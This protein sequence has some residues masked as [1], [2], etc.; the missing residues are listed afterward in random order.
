MSILREDAIQLNVDV[1]TAEMAIR[2][3]GE[4]LVKT[5]QATEAYLQAMISSY[6]DI[7]PYIV[8]APG[9][10]LPHARPEQGVLTQA[11]SMIR[12]KE[13]LAFGHPSNDPVQLVCAM[14]GADQK[15]HVEMLR[16]ISQTLGSK[17]KLQVIMKTSHKSKIISL[18]QT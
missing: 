12:L 18:F 11:L 13:P 7:G 16:Q 9:I 8:I 1:N 4:L 10:A 3:A 15:S 5:G 17:E 6:H 14:G 2:R